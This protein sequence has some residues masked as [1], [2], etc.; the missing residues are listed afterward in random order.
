[1][2]ERVPRVPTSS[3]ADGPSGLR[4]LLLKRLDD[5]LTEGVQGLFVRVCGLAN[6]DA[7]MGSV[8]S[9]GIENVVGD[10]VAIATSATW[11]LAELGRRRGDDLIEDGPAWYATAA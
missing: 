4:R 1:M 2:I 6:A 7:K 10:L 5:R 9:L 3:V 11:S 8:S